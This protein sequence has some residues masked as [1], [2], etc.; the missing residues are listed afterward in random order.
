MSTSNDN[1]ALARPGPAEGLEAGHLT[2]ICCFKRLWH[3]A[4][5][6]WM[7]GIGDKIWPCQLPASGSRGRKCWWCAAGRHTCEPFPT[8]EL[9]SLARALDDAIMRSRAEPSFRHDN[10]VMDR[11]EDLHYAFRKYHRAQRNAADDYEVIEEAE[12]SSSEF[13]LSVA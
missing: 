13:F 6:V 10:E 1:T 7:N 9:R 3:E 5:R 4:Q 8:K 2:C 12:F 11:L